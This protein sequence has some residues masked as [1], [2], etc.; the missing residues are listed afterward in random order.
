MLVTL[1]SKSSSFSPPGYMAHIPTTSWSP[2]Y[3]FMQT[4]T[5]AALRQNRN[6]Y[7]HIQGQNISSQTGDLICDEHLAWEET[8]T[9]YTYTNRHTHH[10]I[11]LDR[12]KLR[13]CLWSLVI[14]ILERTL[15]VFPALFHF[16]FS[17]FVP[18]LADSSVLIW[19][20]FLCS[21]VLPP[22]L[23]RCNHYMFINGRR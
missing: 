4:H 21:S 8:Y 15:H 23:S 16:C 6:T 14:K 2:G 9:I 22:I 11:L 7:A 5:D 19:F 20:L 10:T 12:R 18:L 3:A 13:G 17:N 1:H